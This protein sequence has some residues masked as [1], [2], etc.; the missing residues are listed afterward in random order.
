M[1]LQVLIITEVWKQAD[2]SEACRQA[3]VCFGDL[4]HVQ[5]QV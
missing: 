1:C 4:Q 2:S 5:N 3:K